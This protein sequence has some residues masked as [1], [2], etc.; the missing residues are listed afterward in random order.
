MLLIFL[1]LARNI[2]FVVS[3]SLSFQLMFLENDG[4]FGRHL[5]HLKKLQENYRKHL[6]CYS[7]HTSGAGL[8]HSDC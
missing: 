1:E 7:T 3:Y 6:I 4:Y 5:Q 8:K 2:Q